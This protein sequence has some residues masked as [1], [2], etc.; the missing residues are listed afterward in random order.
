VTRRLTSLCRKS[1]SSGRSPSDSDCIRSLGL[2]LATMPKLPLSHKPIP[3]NKSHL[4]MHVFLI[5]W[6][7]WLVRKWWWEP[8]K[9]VEHHTQ[10]LWGHL[11]KYTKLSCIYMVPVDSEDRR[12]SPGPSSNYESTRSNPQNLGLQKSTFVM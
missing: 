4:Y 12:Q 7:L 6:E 9:W 3:Y 11:L 1:N 2:Q 10:L 5:L 8:R